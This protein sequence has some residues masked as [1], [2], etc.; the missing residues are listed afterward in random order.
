MTTTLVVTK[1]GQITL[2]RELLNYLGIKPGE[3]VSLDQLPGG[4]LRIRAAQPVGSI[5]DFIGL[6]A[7]KSERTLSIEEINKIAAKGWEGEE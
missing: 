1:K 7:G 6:L 4:Q 3:R 5:D 2:K